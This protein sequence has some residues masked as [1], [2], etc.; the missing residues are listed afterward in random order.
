MMVTYTCP[1]FSRVTSRSPL[2]VPK[3]VSANRPHKPRPGEAEG[4]AKMVL[5][6][7]ASLV[8]LFSLLAVLLSCLVVFV[9]VLYRFTVFQIPRVTLAFMVNNA[10]N[11]I[12]VLLA[13][14]F[15]HQSCVLTA[16]FG[17]TVA[18]GFLLEIVLVQCLSHMF[19]RHIMNVPVRWE[20]RCYI[21][22]SAI[23]AI[24]VILYASVC[25]ATCTD[26]TNCNNAVLVDDVVQIVP[27]ATLTCVWLLLLIRLRRIRA[28]WNDPFDRNTLSKIEIANRQKLRQL[29]KDLYNST[30]LPLS[31]Y[32]LLMAVLTALLIAS[33]CV[34]RT[35][36]NSDAIEV[37]HLGF[38]VRS[39]LFPIPYF[40]DREHVSALHPSS[41]RKQLET[42][43]RTSL[44]IRF[45]KRQ[46]LYTPLVPDDSLSRSG[47]NTTNT[48]S[49][50][51]NSNSNGNSRTSPSIPLPPLSSSSLLLLGTAA[52]ASAD[53]IVP[54]RDLGSARRKAR[55]TAVFNGLPKLPDYED[56]IA[57]DE[58]DEE[59]VVEKEKE[60]EEK[61]EVVSSS[62]V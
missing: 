3:F 60:E 52:D 30:F 33:V 45:S 61:E 11:A 49:N 23:A 44:H 59:V 34:R 54:M 24:H 14:V 18:S 13:A 42:R 39:A 9:I 31:Q 26:V 32:F 29:E 6:V 8:V 27:G 7:W 10:V 55:A 53:S 21:L 4:D 1:H 5:G 28:H 37:F 15:G 46:S 58:P 62:T 2:V 16:F 48:T 56:R 36:D 25:S 19:I 51:S 47:T 35:D 41:I 40:L 12:V 22:C 50:S 17:A 38:A 20:F 43:M 57:D